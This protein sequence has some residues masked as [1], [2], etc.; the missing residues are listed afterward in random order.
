MSGGVE[1]NESQ[2]SVV[3][4]WLTGDKNASKSASVEAPAKSVKSAGLGFSSK[5][6]GPKSGLK[7]G[8]GHKGTLAHGKGGNAKTGDV[9]LDRMNKQKHLKSKKDS[10]DMDD[11]DIGRAVGS[12]NKKKP[13]TDAADS[14]KE[15]DSDSDDDGDL[16]GVVENF[17][18]S[19]TVS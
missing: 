3:D 5:G 1:F 2:L 4:S 13:S 10:E 17:S 9:L 15:P 6:K 14:D 18:S 7:E 8:K 16:H 11:E 12:K 19:R